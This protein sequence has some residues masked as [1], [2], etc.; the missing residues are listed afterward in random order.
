MPWFLVDDTFPT[1]PRVL[2]TSLEARG[3]WVTVGSWSSAHLTDGA[4]RD[5]EL[6]SLGGTPELAAELVTAGLWK[7]MKGGYRFV[8]GETCKIPS[9]Q[10]VDN[11]RKLKAE[12]QNRWREGQRRR[13]VDASTDA[14]QDVHQSGS[15]LMADVVNQ[16]AGGNA[17]ASPD[18]IDMI[19][20]EIHAATGRSIDADWAGRVAA[21]VLKGRSTASPLAYI[22][23][24]IRS[25]TDPRTRFLP[26]Y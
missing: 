6:A 11:A 2:A 23:K 25:E 1:H 3:L 7:R 10:A 12:R 20:T 4:V 9:Q 22:R 18:V 15:D 26:Q 14:S 16:G 24:A 8:P 5:H 21:E 13:R 17:R 19:I